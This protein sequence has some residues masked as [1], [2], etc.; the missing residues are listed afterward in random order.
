MEIQII[1]IEA[2][3]QQNLFNCML[4]KNWE[5]KFHFIERKMKHFNN[6]LNQ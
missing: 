3:I 6:S 5:I 1:E 2:L 4:Q